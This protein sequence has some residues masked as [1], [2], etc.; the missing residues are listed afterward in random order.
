MD[1]VTAGGVVSVNMDG[2]AFKQAVV[3]RAFGVVQYHLLV[4]FFEI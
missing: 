1:L 4:E 3:S 2:L